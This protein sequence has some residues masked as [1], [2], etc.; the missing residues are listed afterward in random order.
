MGRS[1]IAPGAITSLSLSHLSEDRA[2]W[3]GGRYVSQE[4]PQCQQLWKSYEVR[5]CS[6]G[7]IEKGAPSCKG[8][9][10]TPSR[11]AKEPDF[12]VHGNYWCWSPL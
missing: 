8:I 9:G 12:M 6:P 2:V 7:G 3:D 11:L 1:G 4:D 10:T 5:Y